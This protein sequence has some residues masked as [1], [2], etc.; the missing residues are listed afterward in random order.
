MSAIGL[1]DAGRGLAV[2]REDVRDRGRLFQN[3]FDRGEIGRGVFRRLVHHDPAPR[4]IQD[5]FRAM[6]VGA[7]DQHQHGAA[8]RHERREHRLD[9]ECARTLHRHGDVVACPVHDLGQPR[10]HFA[11]DLQ[12][13]RIARAPVMH[14]DLFDPFAGG[15]RAWREQQRIAGVGNGRLYEHLAPR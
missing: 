11:V 2:D 9:R 12:E 1:R 14:H 15:Q 7:V 13:C 4:D 8:R 6:A 5:L 10:Q 3:A